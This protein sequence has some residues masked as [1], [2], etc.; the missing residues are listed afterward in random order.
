MMKVGTDTSERD[1]LPPLLRD[2]LTYYGSKMT[3]GEVPSRGTDFNPATL[4][5]WLGIVALIG[6]ENGA[7]RFR[8]MGTKLMARFGQEATGLA[9]DQMDVGSL[10][11]L[12]DRVN[13]CCELTTPVLARAYSPDGRIEFV[14]L[15]LPLR[16]PTGTIDTVLLTALPAAKAS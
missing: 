6:C 3:N 15:L 4:R 9:F 16:G 7:S 2:L 13:R 1:G 5:P 10:G 14:E 12:P 11:D 8:L